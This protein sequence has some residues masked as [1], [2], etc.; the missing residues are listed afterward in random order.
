MVNVPRNIG[1][2]KVYRVWLVLFKNSVQGEIFQNG[3]LHFAIDIL[4]DTAE[5]FGWLG[6]KSRGSSKIGWVSQS[7]I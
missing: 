6:R 1:F 3:S 5:A 2:S 7:M 4:K